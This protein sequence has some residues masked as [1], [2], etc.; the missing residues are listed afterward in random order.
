WPDLTSLATTQEYW[1]KTSSAAQGANLVL[2]RMDSTLAQFLQVEAPILQDDAAANTYYS[3][4]PTGSNGQVYIEPVQSGLNP[5]STTNSYE[6]RKAT[7]ATG[8][9][10]PLQ[11]IIGSES[12]PT[13]GPANGQLWFNALVGV[14]N[15]GQSTVD[16][17][18]ADGAG[19]WQNINLEGFPTQD[20]NP[21][22][23]TLYGQSADPRDNV[24]APV[25]SAGDIWV[26]TDQD[27]YPVIYRW[28][29][30]AWILV[31]NTD[32]TTPNGIIFTDVRSNPMYMN[33]I[34]TGE[35]NGG[36]GN[37]DLDPDAPDADLYPKGFLLWNTRYSTNNVKEWQSPYVFN[38]VPASPDDTNNN[39]LGRW[40]TA[41]GNDP[42]GAPYMGAR[43]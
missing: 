25:L 41:S 8:P 18:I 22:Q 32:Q 26:D 21:G 1:L 20:V 24:P 23:P 19:S 28:S 39:S 2:R 17:M 33:G 35:N 10:A 37:P 43:A 38:G 13:N 29:G 6:F 14:N 34:N 31:D 36:P 7:G 40:V 30:T 5:T 12:V 15:E 3:T 4:V 16:M 27:P 42:G 11:I 9:W